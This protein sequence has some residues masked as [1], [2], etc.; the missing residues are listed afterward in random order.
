MLAWAALLATLGYNYDRHRRGLP[1]ICAITRRT[2]P[3]WAVVAAWSA[4]TSWIIPH[5]LRG[6]PRDRRH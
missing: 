5:L 1:T 4:L 6:Y 2:L 3:P